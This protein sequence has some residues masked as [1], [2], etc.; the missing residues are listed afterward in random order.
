MWYKTMMY[1]SGSL[2]EVSLKAQLVKEL[3]KTHD[4]FWV[5][6]IFLLMMNG[7]LTDDSDL[8]TGSWQLWVLGKAWLDL[9]ARGRG[10]SPNLLPGSTTS[11]F[12]V[13][14]ISVEWRQWFL[15]KLTRILWALSSVNGGG[16]GPG[17]FLPA[18]ER[19]ASSVRKRCLRCRPW[20]EVSQRG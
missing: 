8:I 11:A 20:R 13:H 5:G 15:G 10:L 16:S 6:V 4:D 7:S 12:G 1:S 18:P 17:P 2:S 3:G 9:D 19:R 14:F